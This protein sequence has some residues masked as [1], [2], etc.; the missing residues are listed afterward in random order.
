ME[1][2]SAWVPE[3]E[4]LLRLALAAALGLVLGLERERRGHPA[5]LRTHA[6]VALSG[7]L[8]TCSAMLLHRDIQEAGGS[9]DPLRVV[10][11]IAQALGFIGAG[12]VFVARR[13]MVKNL[14][15]AAS[16]WLAAGIGIVAGAGQFGLAIAA[17]II[18]LALLLARR[19]KKTVAGATRQWSPPHGRLT[20]D[21]RSRNGPPTM[22]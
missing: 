18:G 21:A 1:D 10:Q 4:S 5:G 13:R 15:T 8:L 20:G 2:L 19:R 22:D 16:L 3:A 12:L 14:T 17:T 9:S 6:L 11:G 7:A